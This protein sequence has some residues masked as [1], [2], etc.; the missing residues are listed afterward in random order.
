MWRDGW[1]SSGHL[2]DIAPPGTV[3]HAQRHLAARRESDELLQSVVSRG[4]KLQSPFSSVVPFTGGKGTV[5]FS[6]RQDF[7]HGLLGFAAAR[8]LAN[9]LWDARACSAPLASC[10]ASSSMA[11]S[12]IR[13][14]QWLISSSFGYSCS[15][16]WTR[17]KASMIWRIA[18]SACTPCG[19]RRG[20]RHDRMLATAM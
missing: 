17:S 13:S 5:P 15:I 19:W 14:P 6:R 7:C 8:K 1:G 16:W 12:L 3:S 4:R 9:L 2:D 10:T 20:T 11:S 18:S